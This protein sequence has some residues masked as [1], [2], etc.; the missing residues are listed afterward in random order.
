MLFPSLD[1]IIVVVKYN[2]QTNYYVS[3]RNLWVLNYQLLSEAYSKKGFKIDI[4]MCYNER[5]GIQILDYG[6]CN[7]FLKK[8]EIYKTDILE[9]K[10]LSDMYKDENMEE[11]AYLFK[12][13]LY[14]DFDLKELYSNYSEPYSFE[15]YL[16][17][18]WTSSTSNFRDKIPN[19]LCYWKNEKNQDTFSIYFDLR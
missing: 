18:N 9:I 3:D 11:W 10:E 5:C 8:M 14:I 7:A 12:P 13:S 15:N 4:N 16:P 6:N 2:N 17:E 1:N 19:E